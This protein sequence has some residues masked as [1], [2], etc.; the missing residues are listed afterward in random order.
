MGRKEYYIFRIIA[1]INDPVSVDN[2]LSI[3]QA[4]FN[5]E[6]VHRVAVACEAAKNYT[7]LND[8]STDH[9]FKIFGKNFSPKQDP[10]KDQDNHFEDHKTLS[11][12][13]K[14]NFFRNMENVFAVVK[15]CTL[16]TPHAPTRK[17]HATDVE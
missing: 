2:L 16:R 3:P 6:E 10:G 11:G 13:E 15:L 12:A 8:K 9:S 7:G 5:L 4:D 1:G 14:S 17:L